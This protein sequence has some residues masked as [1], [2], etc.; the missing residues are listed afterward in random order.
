[1]T[2]LQSIQALF[3]YA[4][5]LQT[6]VQLECKIQVDLPYDKSVL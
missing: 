5:S 4:I 6:S 2:N 3:T 1:V